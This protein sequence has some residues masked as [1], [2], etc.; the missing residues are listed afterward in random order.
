MKAW[1]WQQFYT[2]VKLKPG[3]DEKLLQ[4][5]FQRDIAQHAAPGPNAE[6]YAYTPLFQPLKDIHLY[7]AG[8]KFDRAQRGNIT[9]VRAFGIIALFII[10]IGCFNFVNLST[11]RSMQRAK[12]VGVRKA[13]GA[14]RRQLMVQFIA[15][16]CLLSFI[17]VL[18][19]VAITISCV[20]WLNQ[21]AGK[22]I[23]TAIFIRPVVI[24][25]LLLLTLVVGML[26]GFYPALILAGFKPVKVLKG[27]L[28]E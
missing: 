5:K 11:A 19:A 4:S 7:S 9:Y 17:S 16:T 28:S 25:L 27:T 23:S 1:G 14:G 13:I 12:E 22:E 15:E 10:L 24:L 8:F 20:P 2:Y 26:A 6:K 21:F 18:I 3:S